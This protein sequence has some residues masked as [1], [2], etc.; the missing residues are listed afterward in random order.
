MRTCC[1]MRQATSWQ[2]MGTIRDQSRT[3]SATRTSSIPC[4]TPSYHRRASRISGATKHRAVPLETGAISIV[5]FCR[6]RLY[7]HNHT[8]PAQPGSRSVP[9]DKCCSRKKL[10]IGKNRAT[11]HSSERWRSRMS[12]IK[13]IVGSS[14]RSA[15]AA[16]NNSGKAPS[17]EVRTSFPSCTAL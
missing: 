2:A 1:A 15:F 4:A 3:T 17:S 10:I 6:F 12:F 7:L 5:Y 8:R 11:I 16:L 14:R 9:S 13:P